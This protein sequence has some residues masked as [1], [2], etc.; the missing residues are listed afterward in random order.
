M[1]TLP[2]DVDGT[3]Q[4]ISR[5]PACTA[6]RPRRLPR[7][8]QDP[9]RKIDDLRAA[10]T[11]LLTLPTTDPR[12]VGVLGICL[13]GYALRAAASDPR[14]QR[15]ATVAGAY[16]SPAAAFRAQMGRRPTGRPSALRQW[17]LA[18]RSVP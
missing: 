4:S 9:G 11:H 14:V 12:R 1:G 17:G 15:V 10:V 8:R 16:D 3:G 13:G 6:A 7:G 2:R 18:E 5:C